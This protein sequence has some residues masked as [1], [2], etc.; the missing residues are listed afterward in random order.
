MPL[1]S[2][3]WYSASSAHLISHSE[4][5]PG[6]DIDSDSED[7]DEGAFRLEDVSS[8][9][10]VNPTELGELEDDSGLVPLSRF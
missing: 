8:D 9:V 3:T 1:F 10:E 2:Q 5:G 7:E 6:S 4:Q